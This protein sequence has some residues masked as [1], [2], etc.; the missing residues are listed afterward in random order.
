MWIK[1]LRP[2]LTSSSKR[3]KLEQDLEHVTQEMYRRNKELA[4]T[5]RT[6][7]LLQ[8]I[9]SVVLKSHEDIKILSTQISSVIAATAEYPLVAIIGPSRLA[10]DQL[11]TYGFS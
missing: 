6:L 1:H 2:K 5:N 4:D 8:S 11:E 7:A 9:D 10:A 3:Q